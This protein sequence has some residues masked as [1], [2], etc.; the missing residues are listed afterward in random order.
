MDYSDCYAEFSI[1]INEINN[2]LHDISGELSQ[3]ATTTNTPIFTYLKNNGAEA[4]EFKSFNI[5]NSP[6]NVYYKIIDTNTDNTID[7]LHI[8]NGRNNFTSGNKTLDVSD[9]NP[10]PKEKL[11]YITSQDKDNEKYL[12]TNSIINYG[13][14]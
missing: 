7:K 1:D 6:D 9:F 5:N 2:K 14:Y 11:K 13:V 4:R 3:A 10:L 8:F 12:T